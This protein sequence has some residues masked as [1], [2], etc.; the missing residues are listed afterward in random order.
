VRCVSLPYGPGDVTAAFQFGPISLFSG[1]N[2]SVAAVSALFYPAT[3]RVKGDLDG[4]GIPM[5][6]GQPP[7]L[8]YWS[9]R[10]MRRHRTLG[11]VG[12]T[13]GPTGTASLAG[14][15]DFDGDFD[16]EPAFRDTASGV[17][18]V[19][20]TAVTG[21]PVLPLN[22]RLSATGGRGAGGV[23]GT[24]DILWQNDTSKKVVIW[25]MDQAGNRTSGTFTDPDTLLGPTEVLAGPR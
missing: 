13:T 15:D 14:A 21:T 10:A 3:R 9:Y 25:Y 1:S 4:L 18:Y 20:W 12:A 22:W 11:W 7:D 24:Q 6:Q 17:A 8:S 23:H 16:S 5:V 2:T 19:S